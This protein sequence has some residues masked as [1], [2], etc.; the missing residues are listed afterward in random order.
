MLDGHTSVSH[1]YSAHKQGRGVYL[2]VEGIGGGVVHRYALERGQ[3]T[4]LALLHRHIR[5]Q[6]WNTQCQ[7]HIAGGDGGIAINTSLASEPYAK[8]LANVE[9]WPKFHSQLREPWFESCAAAL[10]LEQVHST[11]LQFIQLYEYLALGDGGYLCTNSIHALIAAWLNA[12]RE[13]ERAF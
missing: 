11:L 2:R 4:H 7:C 13:V 10:N 9:Q 3:D 5:C 8:P 12:S 1:N 6:P